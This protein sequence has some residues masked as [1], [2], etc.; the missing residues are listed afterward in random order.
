MRRWLCVFLTCGWLQAAHV[1]ASPIHITD[2]TGAHITL[3]APAKRIVSLSPAITENLFSIGA[4]DLIVGTSSHSDYPA[5]A[6][7]I[8]ITSDFQTIQLERIA[9]LKPDLIIAWQ[10][11]NS[12][13]Q[14][15]VLQQLN[16]P[17]FQQQSQTLADIPLALTQLARLTAREPAAAPIVLAAYQRI[18]LLKDAP[19]P[20]LNAF[21]Q[22]W[23]A[24]LMTLNQ[25]NWVSDALNRCGARNIFANA[26]IT[27]PTVSMES[28][29]AL[30]P[31]LI[32]TASAQASPNQSLDAW[33]SWGNLSAVR[34]NGLLFVDSDAMNRAT[35][36]TLDA[37]TN[38]CHSINTIRTTITRANHV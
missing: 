29:L 19:S 23:H 24:P 26:P 20:N 2:D 30:N 21:Y 31:E 5:G 11:G 18:A 15:A 1:H 33:R 14:L 8:P 7:A 37:A 35:L 9:A 28:V 34:H 17:I 12:P 10:G 25:S 3:A 16:I 4:G 13:A 22:V 27:A 38:L 36:R 32:I 6:S